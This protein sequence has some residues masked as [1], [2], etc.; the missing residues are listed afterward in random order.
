MGSG[1]INQDAATKYH[2]M[3][4]KATLTIYFNHKQS[5]DQIPNHFVAKIVPIQCKRVQFYADFKL[6]SEYD[7]IPITWLPFHARVSLLLN[8]YKLI[9]LERE[10]EREREASFCFSLASLC[11]LAL[12]KQ[13]HKTHHF[14]YNM[15]LALHML[16]KKVLHQRG[17]AIEQG[18][19]ITLCMGFLTFLN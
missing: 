14:H 17:R 7:S 9:I 18:Q 12:P 11:I 19:G 15:S 8:N 16:A 6:T 3:N 4:R 10:R 1:L 13:S 2:N 5:H